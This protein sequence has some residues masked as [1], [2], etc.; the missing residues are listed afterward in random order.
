MDGGSARRVWQF[1]E[2]IH[3]VTYFAPETRAATDALGLRGGWMSYFGCRAAPLGPVAAP[4]VVE[5]FFNFHPAMVAHAVPDVWGYA[6]PQQLL[7]A[8]LVA[9]GDALERIMGEEVDAPGLRRTAELAGRAAD[10]CDVEGRALAAANAAIERSSV[11]HL[12]LWQ[13]VTTLR[14]HRGDGH[15]ATLLEHDI[16]PCEALVLQGATGRSPVDRLQASRGWSA[17]E[18]S[19][20]V[21]A[22]R[23]RGWIAADGTITDGGRDLRD[24]VE[25]ETDQRALEPFRR[26]GEDATDDLVAG[27]RPLA[28]WVMSAGEV[29]TANLMGVPWPPL[30]P[31]GTAPSP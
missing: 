28:V 27:L 7:D 31:T 16:A 2:P 13:A 6:T 12:A 11:P 10:A 25:V 3:A 23:S 9:A 22:L 14:E 30:Q 18:W 19:A 1:A 21:E 5:A 17:T 15:I 29:P 20:A 4:V 24:Q 26:L 8:R